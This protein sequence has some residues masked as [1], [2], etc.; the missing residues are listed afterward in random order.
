MY[1]H[2]F[3]QWRIFKYAKQGSSGQ[4]RRGADNKVTEPQPSE[5]IVRWSKNTYPTRIATPLVLPDGLRDLEVCMSHLHSF[6]LAT[7]GDSRKRPRTVDPSPDMT[8][9]RSLWLFTV[10]NAVLQIHQGR[11]TTGFKLLDT[12]FSDFRQNINAQDTA[13]LAR[14]VSCLCLFADHGLPGLAAIFLQYA[15]HTLCLELSPVH[16]FSIVTRKI[17]AAVFKD[18][19]MDAA[20]DLLARYSELLWESSDP[21]PTAPLPPEPIPGVTRLSWDLVRGVDRDFISPLAAPS[22]SLGWAS[23]VSVSVSVAHLHMS[24]RFYRSARRVIEDMLAH[25]DPAVYPL[26]V[27]IGYRKRWQISHAEGRHARTCADAYTYVEF[28]RNSLGLDHYMTARAIHDCRDYL[29][30]WRAAYPLDTATEA[31]LLAD[32]TVLPPEP[33]E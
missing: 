23:Q 18:G 16:P 6:I 10:N 24:Q 7:C 28:C 30:E 3:K 22:E 5:A 15:Y 21:S 12:V 26:D 8:L 27:A 1:K 13:F 25:L 11:L 31:D 32:I 19:R 20:W 2:R 9:N 29:G 17:Q 14:L 4:P 33:E